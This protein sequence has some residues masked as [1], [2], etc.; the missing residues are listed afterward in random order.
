MPF[1]AEA[2]RRRVEEAADAIRARAPLA[3]RAG[4]ILGTGL[5][6]LAD[7]IEAEAVLP[8]EEIP[9]FPLS[10]VESHTGRLLLGRLEGLPVAALQGR[11]HLYEGYTPQEVTFPVRVLGTLGIEALLVSNA[12]GGMNPHFRRGDLVLLTDHINLQGANPLTG[13]NVDAWGPR[14]PDMSAPY[15]PGLR[16]VAEEA[17][18]RRGIRLMQGVYVAVEGPNLETRA[19]YRFLRLIG[20]D[21]VGMS[22]V[23]EVIVA[24]HMGIRVLAASVVTDECFPDALQPVSIEDVMAAAAEAEPKLTRLFRDVAAHLAAVAQPA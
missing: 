5:G 17:A 20:A 4:L 6:Q 10:T 18:L 16:A 13:P 2:Y 23:P 24:R 9:H 14:F 19:E 11:F 3:P 1:D 7:A 21:L 8:Y 15:D 22:T 12:A